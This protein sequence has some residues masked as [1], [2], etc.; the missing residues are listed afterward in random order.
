MRILL[1][2]L[3]L[4][5]VSVGPALAIEGVRQGHAVA[6]TVFSEIEKKL[7]R[8]YFD[9]QA[10]R[11]SRDQDDR[12]K[13]GKA[14]AK[15]KNKDRGDH[16]RGGGGDDVDVDIDIDLDG[17]DGGKGLPPGLAKRDDLPPGLEMQI[18]RFGR[19]PPGLAK[20]DLPADLDRRLGALRPGLGRHVVGSDVVL[21]EVATGIVLDI[22]YDVIRNN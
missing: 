6:D 17:D 4:M 2:C 7:I 15:A 9:P 10:N 22:L 1:S 3:G 18:D 19:L 8:E 16:G 14:K 21:I 11:D 12:D 20:R 5:L 13:P